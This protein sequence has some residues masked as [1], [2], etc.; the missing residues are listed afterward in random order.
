MPLALRSP[1]IDEL[2]ALGDLCARSKAIWGYDEKFIEACRAELSFCARDLLLTQIVV[3]EENERVI[4][5]AQVK[6][7]ESEA[8]L[9]KLFVDPT[10]LRNGVGKV[11]FAWAADRARMMGARRLLIEADP[12]AAPF[13]RRMGA[14]DA[15][16]APSG[17][18]AGRMLPKLVL[19]LGPTG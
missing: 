14:R 1:A 8:D 6:V 7:V 17:S 3:A 18:I 15:G 11:L 12:D 16:L 9:L 10:A 13:Y 2:P 4:G 5:V 19:E